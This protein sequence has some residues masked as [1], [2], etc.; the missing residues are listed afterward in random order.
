MKCE[1][2]QR[3]VSQFYQAYDKNE[4]LDGKIQNKV[5]FK[6]NSQYSFNC[7]VFWPKFRH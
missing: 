2:A 7:V 5:Y 4:S 6:Q 1:I 3:W